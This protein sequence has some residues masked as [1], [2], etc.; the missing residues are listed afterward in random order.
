MTMLLSQPV[1][2]DLVIRDI[3]DQ[4]NCASGTGDNNMIPI[5]NLANFGH[6]LG[7]QT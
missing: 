5:L 1:N 6:T 4:T 2:R 7:M 3:T